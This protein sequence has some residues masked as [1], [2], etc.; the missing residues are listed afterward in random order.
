MVNLR[1][2][3][4]E[5]AG[6]DKLIDRNE[7]KQGLGIR[8]DRLSNR[9]FDIFDSD[10]NGYIDSAEFMSA[11]ESIINGDEEDKIRFAFNIHDVDDSGYIDRSELRVLIEQSFIENNLDFDDFQ[12]DFLVDEFFSRGDTDKSG[13]IDFNEFLEIARQY[14]DFITGF[15]VNP[16]SW[17]NPDRYDENID[18]V[19]EIIKTDTS[20]Q[21]QNLGAIEWLLIPRM[22]YMYNM[23][24]NRKKNRSFVDLEAIHLLPSRVMELVIRPPEN[25]MFLP[26]DYLYI[27]CPPI[28]KMKWYPFTIIRR[29]NDGNLILHVK[30]NNSW[31][32]TLYDDTIDAIKKSGTVGWILRIDGPYGSS[33]N[34][35]LRSEH[36]ILVGAGH[37][38]TKLAPILQDIAMRYQDDDQDLAFD[39]I[40]LYWLIADD[41][42]FEWFIKLLQEIEFIGDTKFFHYHIYFIDKNPLALKEKLLYLKTDILNGKTDI[43]LLDDHGVKTHIGMP[44]WKNEISRIKKNTGTN[45]V[46]LF[47]CGPGKLKGKLQEE[48]LKQDVSFSQKK[49]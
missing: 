48:C 31:T 35:I 26:G 28:S 16:I 4:N 15:A 20:L 37:G 46:D 22:I 24:L 11:I 12:L 47:Y 33:T 23:L 6:A 18:Q 44:E 34:R 45:K 3:F 27:N 17:L 2:T 8:D 19:D 38:V 30:S 14:P 41:M 29:D 39:K 36:P 5:I 9:L 13:T 1:N 43:T 40:H 32:Q 21:V 49:F 25:F 7:F 10:H 42:Y